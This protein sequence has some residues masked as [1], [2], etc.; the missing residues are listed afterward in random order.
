M[1]KSIR[2][3]KVDEYINKSMKCRQELSA[4]RTIVLDCELAEE[5]KWRAPCYTF[6]G[7]NVVLVGRLKECCT[8]SFPKG[9]LLKDTKGILSKPGQNTRAARVIRFSSVDEMDELKTVLKSYLREA[10]ALER[11]GKKIEFKTDQELGF[12]DELLAR[13]EEDVVFKAAFEALTP[14]RQRGYVL[15]FSGAKQ[16]KTRASRIESCEPKIL[17]KKGF[18]DCV[19]GLSKKMPTC[20]GSH[21]YAI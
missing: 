1:N 21:K 11:S 16:S 15:H 8:L 10:V 17:A 3:P 14:G 5:L 9:A 20:D 2:N 19:C 12:P 4:L 7:K 6:D 13:F 18:H